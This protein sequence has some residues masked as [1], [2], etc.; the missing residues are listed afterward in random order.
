[1]SGLPAAG[2]GHYEVFLYDSIIDSQP[3]GA[4]SAAGRG[5][6]ALPVNA[7]H[8]ASIDISRQVTGDAIPDGASVLR[9]PNPAHAG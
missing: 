3:L 6:F 7:A 9:A 4:L 2:A 5:S 8:Y 1:M